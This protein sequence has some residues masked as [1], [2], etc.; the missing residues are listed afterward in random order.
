[1]GRF[2]KVTLDD[3]H[4]AA[5]EHGYR[6]DKSHTFRQHCQI[7]LLKAQGRKSK[8][9][10]AIVGCGEKCV[11]DWLHRYKAEGIE[12]L[13]IKA[14]RGRKSILS[15]KTDAVAVREAVTAHRQRISLSLIHI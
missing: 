1:M 11:N 6:H 2:I 14:G 13:R 10:A 4:R 5:L 9:I 15:E 8:E 3:K 12:G 7:V